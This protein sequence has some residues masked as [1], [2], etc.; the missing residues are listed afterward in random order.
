MAG[1]LSIDRWQA[2]LPNT[3]PTDNMMRWMSKFDK[4]C[5]K[6]CCF[7]PLCGCIRCTNCR[8]SLTSNDRP[9]VR[10]QCMEC[11]LIL[12]GHS[13]RPELCEACFRSETAA[14]HDHALFCK[15]DE[16][17]E[18]STIRRHKTVSRKDLLGSDF[19]PVQTL[20][21]SCPVCCEP[22]SATNQAVSPPGCKRG[23]GESKSDPIL[24][25]I[26][27]QV[28]YCANCALMFEQSRDRGTYCD[29]TAYCK[30]CQHENEMRGWRD[31]FR[32]LFSRVDSPNEVLADL[33]K[34]H[35]Q[36][37]IR[38]AVRDEFRERMKQLNQPVDESVLVTEV[39]VP[40]NECED[41]KVCAIPTKVTTE[42]P[43][44]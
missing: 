17:G 22:F 5:F 30:C 32:D 4:P 23:H 27:T 38:A 16:R 1:T 31:E 39:L 34:L 7:S 40:Q 25:I 36:P 8:T 20:Q 37:W 26:D 18:H 10:Y 41:G 13:S 11:P 42:K 3:I 43:T 44:N 24:G 28:D 33:L 35:T 14:L 19:I 29:I 15:V 6:G 9:K 2:S 21:D 12:K